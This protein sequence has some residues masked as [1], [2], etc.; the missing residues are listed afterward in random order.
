MYLFISK[1][2]KSVQYINYQIHPD[3]FILF[4][5]FV[6]CIYVFHVLHIEL[7]VA[8]LRDY[9]YNVFFITIFVD[10][11]TMGFNCTGTP[12]FIIKIIYFYIY[13]IH[14]PPV[15]FGDLLLLAPILN[16]L[17]PQPSHLFPHNIPS[18]RSYAPKDHS[19]LAHS[20][21]SHQRPFPTQH[22]TPLKLIKSKLP[23]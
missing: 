23:A 20:H 21:S 5:H 9:W 11:I 6:L 12:V 4:T 22:T 2:K 3:S 13:F 8:H 17:N 7:G 14:S 10:C 15:I 19:S 18:H 16:T 1:T